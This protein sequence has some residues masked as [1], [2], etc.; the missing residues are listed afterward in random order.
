MR[1]GLFSTILTSGTT[2]KALV[3]GADSLSA[4]TIGT[5][6][7]LCGPITCSGQTSLFGL[8]VAGIVSLGVTNRN[9][10]TTALASFDLFN[11]NGNV[12]RVLALGSGYTTAGAYQQ[13]SLVLDSLRNE[14]IL[15][16]S[17]NKAIYFYPG[18][19]TTR[20]GTMFPS[21]GFGWGNGVSDP[22][23][24]R[25]SCIDRIAANTAGTVVSSFI[26]G[27][28]LNGSDAIGAV[29]ATSRLAVGG[30]RSSQWDAVA[31]YASAAEIVR[32]EANAVRL[33]SAVVLTSTS[34]EDL[35]LNAPATNRSIL[36]KYNGTLLGAFA[37][38]GGFAIGAST[39]D[40]GTGAFALAGKTK[41]Y[42]GAGTSVTGATTIF[43]AAQVNS[44]DVGV[45][46]LV[47]GT[48]S[49][50]ATIQFTDIVCAI[51]NS[52]ATL[53]AGQSKGA[54]DSRTYT[55]SGLD[56]QLAMG[57]NTYKVWAMPFVVGTPG[58]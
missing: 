43:T 26:D 36:F 55:V 27:Y 39:P 50:D 44:A 49:G 51:S 48:K 11:N 32:A 6:E 20:R 7:V 52:G 24:S 14:L 31:L 30:Y 58:S 8:S 23:V 15:L 35:V 29:T 16:A 21:G 45:W 56:V 41:Y 3:V 1:P 46:L 2:T 57:A 12:G 10:G 13:D 19:S 17:N 47:S 18:S 4:P 25:L 37:A 53:V 9:T 38:T 40:P 5:G 34:G 28:A 22:G 42:G 33:G 54:A